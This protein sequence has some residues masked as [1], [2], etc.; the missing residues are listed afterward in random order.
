MIEHCLYGV[1]VLSDFDLF[2]RPV[3]LSAVAPGE[4]QALNFLQLP[5]TGDLPELSE[6]LPLYQ[7]RGR[8]LSLNSDRVLGRS[9]SVQPWRMGV[10]GLVDFHWRGGE[11]TLYY[12]PKQACTQELLVFWFVHIFLP[13]YLAVERGYDF[14]HAAARR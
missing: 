5:D 12:Q 9:V 6:A 1:K 14:I 10:S 8:I 2:G 11:P 3:S 7:S 4:H 13:L